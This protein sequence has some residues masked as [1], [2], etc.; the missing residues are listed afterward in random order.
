[1]VTKLNPSKQEILNI[2]KLGKFLSLNME[3]KEVFHHS[4][5]RSFGGHRKCSR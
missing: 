3:N 4:K 2:Q 5:T 1:M